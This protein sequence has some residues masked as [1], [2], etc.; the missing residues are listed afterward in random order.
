MQVDIHILLTTK[1]HYLIDNYNTCLFDQYWYFIPRAYIKLITTKLMRDRRTIHVYSVNKA[2]CN[3]CC[4]SLS[5]SFCTYNVNALIPTA[6]LR[7]LKN[8]EFISG[9]PIETCRNSIIREYIIRSRTWRAL[10][11]PFSIFSL[12]VIKR[13]RSSS[14]E[15]VGLPSLSLRWYYLWDCLCRIAY[16]IRV[17]VWS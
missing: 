3:S 1:I 9:L 17:C 6:K 11:D 10:C 16:L 12:C 14:K 8:E 2:A 4:Y 13:A 5:N 15:K 7:S